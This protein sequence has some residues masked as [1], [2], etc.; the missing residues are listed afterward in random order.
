M[1]ATETLDSNDMGVEL[2]TPIQPDS[3]ESKLKDPCY[4]LSNMEEWH[5]FISD[6]VREGLITDLLLNRKGTYFV[7][8][9]TRQAINHIGYSETTGEEF[10]R[11]EIVD[12]VDKYY[13]THGKKV[14]IEVPV[15]ERRV[16]ERRQSD[17]DRRVVLPGERKDNYFGLSQRNSYRG[18]P[19]QSK[20]AKCMVFKPNEGLVVFKDKKERNLFDR[21]KGIVR[22]DITD[23]YD[24][25]QVVIARYNQGILSPVLECVECGDIYNDI[26]DKGLVR[27]NTKA[28]G[29]KAAFYCPGCRSDTGFKGIPKYH[30]IV[31]KLVLT[32]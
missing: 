11:T 15:I 19:R 26:K 16:E 9:S 32:E 30:K 6:K 13:S 2:D 23:I 4:Y 1:T 17:N 14:V 25:F 28:K 5:N 12:S 22:T 24:N 18:D 27:T 7:V 31:P 21:L 20:P 29:D 10:I 8:P 3:L